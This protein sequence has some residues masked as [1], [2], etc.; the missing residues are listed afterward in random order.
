MGKVKV[1]KVELFPVHNGQTHL[2]QVTGPRGGIRAYQVPGSQDPMWSVTT[3]ISNTVAKPGLYGWYNRQGREAVAERLTPHIGKVLNSHLLQQAL[4]EASQRP[5]K[6][7]DAAG[8]L[9]T[10][11]HELIA[12]YITSQIDGT[13]F[14]TTVPEDLEVVWESF[15]QWEDSSDI[16]A[17]I[18]SEFAV[19]SHEHQ[20]AGSVD[21]LARNSEGT[22]LILDW[23]T[24]GKLYDEMALQVA[25]Y[26]NAIDGLLRL[27]FGFQTGQ[28]ARWDMWDHI[29]PWVIRLNK[30]T[31]EFEARRV[32]NP[33]LALDGFLNAM[34]MWHSLGLPGLTPRAKKEIEDYFT[35]PTGLPSVWGE[36]KVD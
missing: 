6:V 5:E 33:Q 31:A 21:V 7:R 30:E 36:E 29:Q 32:K 4:D 8:D 11:A 19:Y 18:K 14:T 9:G 23:K 27:H 34:N 10:R 12:S 25:A 24:S 2:F 17:Y 1:Q 20:Y 15:K 16:Q 3:I 13:A 22:Y 26:A 28:T 35:I